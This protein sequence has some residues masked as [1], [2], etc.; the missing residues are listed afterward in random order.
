MGG[1]GASSEKEIADIVEEQTKKAIPE[2]KKV[3]KYD[4]SENV[5]KKYRRIFEN[6]PM[7]RVQKF[8]SD[9]LQKEDDYFKIKAYRDALGQAMVARHTDVVTQE[10]HELALE[11]AFE[12]T[13]QAETAIGKA[14]EAVKKSPRC[15]ESGRRYYPI[16][17]NTGEF[18]YSGN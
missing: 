13:F 8:V 15:W 5:I 3:G 4:L 11:Q 2:L 7:E 1:S 9:A 17:Q 10:L 14:F 12:A 18:G 16:Y 6:E